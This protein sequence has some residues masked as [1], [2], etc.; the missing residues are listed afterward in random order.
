MSRL[1]I[2]MFGQLVVELD[3][4]RAGSFRT[5]KVQ[6]LLIYLASEPETAHR[7]ELLTTL[8]WPGMPDSS[9]RSNLRQVLF[10]LRRAIPDFEENGEPVPLLIANRY[11]IQLN[12][13][14][15]V[16]IDTAE[17]EALLESVQN[18][19]HIDLLSCHTCRQTLESAV[20]I[21]K[22]PFLADFYLEDSNEFEEWAEINRQR[23]RRKMLMPWTH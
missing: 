11:T 14:A 19:A 5:K 22:G 15:K 6:A 10:H 9:A 16:V 2:S 4:E 1:N 23:F 17:F 21:N 12:S 13:Q 8:L 7:R 3:G 18:H 20:S